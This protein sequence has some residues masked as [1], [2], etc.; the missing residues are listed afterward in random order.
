M[1]A[2]G[3]FWNYIADCVCEV[4]H[5][6]FERTTVDNIPPFLHEVT[7]HPSQIAASLTIQQRC[8]TKAEQVHRRLCALHGTSLV[9]RCLK[10]PEEKEVRPEYFNQMPPLHRQLFALS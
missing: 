2:L 4:L 7:H 10:M 3:S 6:R 5:R 9:V 1:T 8:L